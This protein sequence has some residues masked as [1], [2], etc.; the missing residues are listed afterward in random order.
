ML[1]SLKPRGG[2]VADSAPELGKWVEARVGLMVGRL[3][4][5]SWV[6]E[7]SYLRE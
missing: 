5:S 4:M 1:P 7:V 2:G 3:Q 6:M